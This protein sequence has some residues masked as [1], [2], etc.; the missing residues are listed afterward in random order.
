MM[1]KSLCF[2]PVKENNVAVMNQQEDSGKNLLDGDSLQE[3]RPRCSSCRIP[4]ST[5]SLVWSWEILCLQNIFVCNP[6]LHE[7]LYLFF[8]SRHCVYDIHSIIGSKIFIH[9][10]KTAKCCFARPEEHDTSFPSKIWPLARQQK[11]Q[12]SYLVIDC[13]LYGMYYYNFFII[14]PGKNGR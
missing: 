1:I 2:K 6:I 4:S 12:G 11:Q 10:R 5:K 9:Q 8:H 14:K 13:T 7:L 3:E